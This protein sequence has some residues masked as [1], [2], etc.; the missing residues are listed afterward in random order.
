[1]RAVVR[2]VLSM[3]MSR[4]W[5][6]RVPNLSFSSGEFYNIQLFFKILNYTGKY[7]YHVSCSK[8][9]CVMTTEVIVE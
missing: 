9:L 2:A 8:N 1:V 4:L 6:L 5:A 3:E 7:I